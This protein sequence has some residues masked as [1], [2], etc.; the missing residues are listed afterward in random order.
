[1]R[2][3]K[4]T[5]GIPPM[6]VL[7]NFGRQF[8]INSRVCHLHSCCFCSA[9]LTIISLSHPSNIDINNHFVS[10]EEN[11]LTYTPDQILVSNGAKQSILQAV[12][13]VCFPGDEVRQL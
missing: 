10:A 6:L 7:W 11:G 1:M 8:V 3:V 5:R 9:L 4:V 13:A 12:L 2:F